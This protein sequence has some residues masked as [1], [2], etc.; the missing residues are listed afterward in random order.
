MEPVIG[1]FYDVTSV[2]GIEAVAE[3]LGLAGFQPDENDPHWTFGVELSPGEGVT[4][5]VAE[6][7]IEGEATE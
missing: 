2:A 1:G 5:N 4:L 6:S 3:C 7:G